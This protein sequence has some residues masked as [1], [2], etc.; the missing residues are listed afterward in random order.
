MS[1][2]I[3]RSAPQ[4]S[5]T[6]S[7]RT[8]DGPRRRE[9]A[10]RKRTTPDRCSACRPSK[11]FANSCTLVEAVSSESPHMCGQE[12]PSAELLGEPRMTR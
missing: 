12:S 11:N 2:A 10:R 8:R 4:S 1:I 7:R 9:G 6:L 3:E 5:P